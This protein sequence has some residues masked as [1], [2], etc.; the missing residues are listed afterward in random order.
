[1]DAAIGSGKNWS[2]VNKKSGFRIILTPESSINQ[3]GIK[4]MKI[5]VTVIDKITSEAHINIPDGLS[6]SGIKQHIT[7]LYNSGK[8]LIDLK[9]AQVEFESISARIIQEQ[10]DVKREVIR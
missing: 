4:N 10:A 7:D 2:S 6:D 1:M 9:I 5:I 8:M 3:M